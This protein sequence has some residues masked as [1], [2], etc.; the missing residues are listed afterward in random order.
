MLEGRF[1]PPKDHWPSSMKVALFSPAW[2]VTRAQN[3]IVTYVDIMVRALREA[4]HE[5]VVVTPRWVPEKSPDGGEAAGDVF[6]LP[7]RAYGPG[8][9]QLWSRAR[10]KFAGAK[11]M[12]WGDAGRRISRALEAASKNRPVDVVDIEESFGMAGFIA[13]APVAVRLHGPHF[14]GQFGRKTPDDDLRIAMEGRAIRAAAGVTSPSP[15]LLEATKNFYGNI[16]GN[17]AVIPNPVAMPPENELWRYDE[18]DPNLILFVGRFDLRKGADVML[19]AFSKV[20]ASRKRL[21]LVMAGRDEGLEIETGE[22]LR[23]AEYAA[24]FLSEDVASRIEF[25]GPVAPEALR[26]L[27]RKAFVYVSASRFECHSYAVVEALGQGCP[28]IVS[29]TLGPPEFFKDGEALL[30]TEI[31]NAEQLA[32]QIDSLCEHPQLAKDLS[33]AARRGVHETFAPE[34]I[35]ADMADFYTRTISNAGRRA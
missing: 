25:L 8:L 7:L 16:G 6:E 20:A 28:A 21:R 13:G 19:S 27:R 11:E 5:C 33:G 31:A 2:P 12:A 26:K 3:G 18:C 34:K 17:H 29:S 32:A 23:Y 10:S 35:A 24:R 9:G 4:G 1:R 22:K 30:V 14:V 15:G